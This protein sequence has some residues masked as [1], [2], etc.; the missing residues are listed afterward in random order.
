MHDT[1]LPRRWGK[2]NHAGIGLVGRKRASPRDDAF[3]ASRRSY[4]VKSPCTCHV[5]RGGSIR[6][7]KRG[8]ALM[9]VRLEKPVGKS[10]KVEKARSFVLGS[11]G[12]AAPAPQVAI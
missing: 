10:R 1:P 12:P 9:F 7:E 5:I 6:G 2:S 8:N 3:K 4:T 11:V